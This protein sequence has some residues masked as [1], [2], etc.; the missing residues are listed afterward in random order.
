M[1]PKKKHTQDLRSSVPSSEKIE[2][3]KTMWD[4]CCDKAKGSKNCSMTAFLNANPADGNPKI[5][6]SRGPV[7]QENLETYVALKIKSKI[8]TSMSRQEACSAK[9]IS[10]NGICSSGTP[11]WGQRKH[12]I[13]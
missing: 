8:A 5:F 4:V 11:T 1:A 9:T 6:S 3:A 2:A 7:K 10:T 12:N 13:G